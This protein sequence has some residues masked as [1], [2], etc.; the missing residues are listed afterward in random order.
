MFRISSASPRLVPLI[1]SYRYSFQPSENDI[2]HACTHVQIWFQRCCLMVPMYL[3]TSACTSVPASVQSV[4]IE[5]SLSRMRNTE[6]ICT[7]HYAWTQT[8]MISRHILICPMYANSKGCS[9]RLMCWAIV[10]ALLFSAR[11]KHFSLN[12]STWHI[13]HTSRPIMPKVLKPCWPWDA[14]ARHVH[15]LLTPQMSHMIGDILSPLHVEQNR[16]YIEAATQATCVIV[17]LEGLF[18]TLYGYFV[19]FNNSISMWVAL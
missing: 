6:D 3:W 8:S 19:S 14:N 16:V 5:D 11:C 4:S 17:W 10:W 13:I 2:E 18:N 9:S 7:V 15:L 12:T 1:N